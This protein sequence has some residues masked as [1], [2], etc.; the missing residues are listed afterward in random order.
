[1]NPIGIAATVCISLLFL[2]GSASIIVSLFCDQDFPS[3]KKE[4]PVK[5]KQKVQEPIVAD[6][7]PSILETEDFDFDDLEFD[8]DILE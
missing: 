6:D 3:V 5:Q 2:V 4:E 7:P 8:E 1:M